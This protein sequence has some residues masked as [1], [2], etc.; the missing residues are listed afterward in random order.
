M[1]AVQCT[2][3]NGRLPASVLKLPAILSQG[4]ARAE[5]YGEEVIAGGLRQVVLL[6]QLRAEACEVTKKISSTLDALTHTWL[7][8]VYAPAL[9]V[10]RYGV[11]LQP[12]QC[13]PRSCG[14][15]PVNY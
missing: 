4:A 3:T 1:P 10:E 8:N 7:R 14:V 12:L 13:L 9:Q 2:L 5:T 11:A 15:K 6:T